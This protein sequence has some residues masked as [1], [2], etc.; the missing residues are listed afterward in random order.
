[1]RTGTFPNE[2]ICQ[3]DKA[4]DSIGRFSE[5][6]VELVEGVAIYTIADE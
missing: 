5:R 3:T 6:E 1:M 2:R 4:I